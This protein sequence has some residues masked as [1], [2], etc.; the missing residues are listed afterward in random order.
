MAQGHT[1]VFRQI[2]TLFGVGS[3]AG[4]DDDQL[5]ELFLA[6]RD[7]AAELAFEVLVRR[8]G[9]MVLR[10]CRGVL[11]DSHAAED[12]LQATFLVLAHRA[13]EVRRR[14]L[15][16]NWLHGVA[17]R[18]A[19]KART[20]AA[21]RRRHE[22]G[23]A[24]LVSEVSTLDRGPDDLAPLLH[25]EVGRLPERYRAP[26]I[27]CHLEGM[28][29][30]AAARSLRLSE[31]T[32]RGR[33]AR[34]RRLLRDR[35]VHRGVSLAA[36]P[37]L[38]ASPW[39]PPLA[40]PAE[41]VE[42]TVRSAL[43]GL[44]SETVIAGTASATVARLAG[45]VLKEFAMA[46]VK[47]AAGI[48][49]AVGVLAI[50]A[51]NGAPTGREARTQEAAVGGATGPGGPVNQE[52]GKGGGLDPGRKAPLDEALAR[53]VEG[54]I[55]ETATI[56]ADGM[57]LA[58][59]PDWDRGDV[60][61]LAVANNDGGVRTLLNWEPIPSE[62][63]QAPGRRYLLALYSRKTTVGAKPGRVLAFEVTDAWRERTS[64]TSRPAYEP[65]PA[66]SYEF[67]PGE[68]WKLF[69]V[70]ALVQAQAAGR[71]E[72]RGVL[73]RFL[74]EDRSGQR[75][76]WSGYAFASREAGGEWQGRRPVLLVVDPAKNP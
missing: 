44:A 17:H 27:L 72:R 41:R 24:A 30:D 75:K 20:G 60:D 66:A 2:R 55:V 23:A 7:E 12:A 73:L 34:A 52:A 46:K 3:L 54:R 14:A 31:T 49:L 56:V 6:R 61:N 38:G 5:L 15:L 11:N 76:D 59:L 21:R 51:S 67:V 64:W 28:T 33:L 29:Y 68:G 9:P 36:L 58:Y 18:T 16:G 25:E 22:Q 62:E 35:L 4:L 39:W 47:V 1:E 57:V 26:V 50:G 37:W 45:E 43:Q 69:D 70:T 65:E 40:I 53:A 74:S 71:K 19:L 48:V 32:L 8:H 13:G 10:V 63:A 42:A